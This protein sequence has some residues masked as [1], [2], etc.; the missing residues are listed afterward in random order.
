MRIAIV[1]AV[2]TLVLASGLAGGGEE[3][4]RDVVER[5]VRAAGGEA[6]VSAVQ[7]LKVK[8]S[9]PVQIG[10][11]VFES[12]GEVTLADEDRM[13]WSGKVHEWAIRLT[14]SADGCWRKLDDLVEP[15]RPDIADA[16]RKVLRGL[17]AAQ[18]LTPLK[19]EGVKLTHRGAGKAQD[20]AVVVV[21]AVNDDLG[22]QDL[23]FDRETGLPIRIEARVGLGKEPV[24][25]VLGDYKD[26][27]GARRFTKVIVSFTVDS[28]RFSA[29]VTLSDFRTDVRPTDKDFTKPE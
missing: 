24:T 21:R 15:A 12:T 1:M 16:F 23:Y 9:G 13:A 27:A 11:N 7:S 8:T 25:C 3:S 5:A 17:R 29:D 20:R 14:L 10:V 2:T 4:A 6:K 19:G 28:I 22:E 26:V 18:R